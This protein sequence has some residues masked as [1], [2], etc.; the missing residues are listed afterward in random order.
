MKIVFL[1]YYYKEKIKSKNRVEFPPLGMLYVCA[2]LEAIGQD[3]E[4]FYFDENTPSIEFPKADIYAYSI[5]SSVSYPLYI[6]L[7]PQLRDNATLH[8]AGNTHATIFPKQVMDEMN[9]DA[10]FC[11]AGEETITRW[12]KGGCRERG[13]IVGGLLENLDIPFP[14]RHLI[15]DKYIYMENRV[16]GKSKKSIS[17]ISSRGCVFNCKFCAIQNRGKV[18]FRSLN[19]IDREVNFILRQYPQCDG[20]TL[21]DET[22]TLNAMHAVGVSE[23]FNK[24][25]LRWECNSRI[26]TLNKTIINALSESYC[27]EIRIGI[28]TGSQK[29]LNSMKKGFLIEQTYET[30]KAL[31]RAGVQVKIYLMHGYPGEDMSTT[32]ETIR[33]LH[34]MRKYIDRISLY[35]FTPLPGSPIYEE[36]FLNKQEWSEYSIYND[37]VRWWGTKKEQEVL[38][39][40]YQR[41]K[42]VVDEINNMK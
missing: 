27:A 18:A 15:P 4:V 6:S 29:L 5:S 14:A 24:Y 13:I 11:G 37:N 16:G 21:L 40:S 1:Y 36:T 28:E 38:N 25:K 7:A 3:V 17:M 12:I 33:F 22:F 8:I 31:K 23:I 19:D 20:I 34:K 2:T 41:L 9:L 10:V 30:F 42:D 39:T 32:S 26:D 35:R